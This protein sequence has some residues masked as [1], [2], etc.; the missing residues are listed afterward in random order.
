MGKR[1]KVMFTIFV[2][3]VQVLQFLLVY[4]IAWLN[5]RTIEFLFIFFSFQMNRMVFGKSYHAD[6]LS[7]CTLIT[8]VTFYLLIKGVIPLNISLFATPLFGVYLSYVLNIIHELIDNQEVPKPFVKK[9]LREQIIEIL[10]EDLSE[11]HINE[12]CRAK[13]INPKVFENIEGENNYLKIMTSKS[14]FEVFPIPSNTFVLTSTYTRKAITYKAQIMKKVDGVLV[15]HSPIFELTLRPSIGESVAQEVVPPAFKTAYDEMVNVTKEVKDKL[16]KGEFKGDKGDKGNKGD[17][18]DPYTESQEFKDYYQKVKETV[19]KSQQID[20]DV[21]DKSIAFNENYNS[22]LDSFNEN[23]VNKTNDFNS[24]VETAKNE[25]AK[26]KQSS[27]LEIENKTEYGKNVINSNKNSALADINDKRVEA[28]EEVE[29]QAKS[30]QVQIDELKES[31]KSQNEE[32]ENLKATVDTKLTQPYINNNDSTHITSSDNGLMNELVIKGNTVQ[33]S[34]KGL[35]LFDYRLL[36]SLTAY[37]VTLT[38]NNDGSFSVFGTST[39]DFNFTSTPFSLEEGTYKLSDNVIGLHPKNNNAR[40]QVYSS[41]TLTSISTQNSS[42]SNAIISAKLSASDDYVLRIRCTKGFTYNSTYKIMFYQQGDGTFEPYTGGKPSP[43]PDYPQE[44]KGVDKIE[45]KVVGKNLFD[46]SKINSN[47]NTTST[48]TINSVIDG[49]INT[50]WNTSYQSADI[51]SNNSSSGWTNTS[52]NSI[53][54]QPNTYTL[55]FKHKVIKKLTTIDNLRDFF[56]RILNKTDNSII[57]YIQFTGDFANFKNISNTFTLNE[58]TSIYLLVSCNNCQIEI[59][60]IQL[61]IGSTATSYQPY[62][63]QTISYTLQNPLYKLSDTVYDYIDLNKGKIVRNVGIIEF[64]GSSDENWL[65]YS[66]VD[67]K[68]KVFYYNLLNNKLKDINKNEILL[69]NKLIYKYYAWISNLEYIFSDHIQ[70]HFIYITMPMDISDINVFK[71]WLSQNPITIYYQLEIPTEEDIPEELLTQLQSLKTYYPQTNIIWNTEVKPYIN[72]D[73][74][75]NLPA[76]LEDKDNKDIIYD[77]KIETNQK[78]LENQ[79]TSEE[80]DN[81]SIIDIDYRVTCLEL[82]MEEQ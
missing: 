41:N 82:D 55:S 27:I 42:E 58:A 78:A 1:E 16:D 4:S 44:V 37:G 34:T 65:Q 74:K 46:I 49:V 26:Q 28:I 30:Y 20:K 23:S 56:I 12:I 50:Q 54:L 51:G 36:S 64:D 73:Y 10:G 31:D 32:I 43:N 69:S 59:K 79:L 81:Q 5:N 33:N 40:V 57:T 47:S 11:E 75:L 9:R 22:K 21:T 66:S 71:Q 7:K 17:K 72:F 25:I 52:N 24:S 8:L 68:L 2:V 19:E 13:G 67:A 45:G 39:S 35:N 14:E 61:E 77:K 63:E 18:G 15:V 80:L 70:Y 62:V 48:A 29:A 76:W 60:D 6:S 38:N 3:I 53:K